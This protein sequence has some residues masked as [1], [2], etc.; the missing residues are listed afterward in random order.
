MSLKK[1]TD[2]LICP[3]NNGERYLTPELKCKLGRLWWICPQNLIKSAMIQKY[4]LTAE[5]FHEK[6]IDC[7]M[8]TNYQLC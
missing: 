3:I 2:S 4:N 1:H 8:G 6:V 5:V 7:A